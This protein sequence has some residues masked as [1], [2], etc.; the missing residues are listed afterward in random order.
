[1]ILY[2]FLSHAAVLAHNLPYIAY[3]D[4]EER[5]WELLFHRPLM[6]DSVGVVTLLYRVPFNPFNKFTA[7]QHSQGIHTE[8]IT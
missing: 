1:M 8:E 5:V 4:M 7:L 2:P 6:G 3:Y